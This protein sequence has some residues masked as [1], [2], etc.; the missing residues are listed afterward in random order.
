VLEMTKGKAANYS[1]GNAVLYGT[2]GGNINI[3][4]QGR[5]TNS[6]G[7]T[8]VATFTAPTMATNIQLNAQSTGSSI[9]GTTPAT[10]NSGITLSPTN[11]DAAA[12]ATGFGS[13]AFRPGGASYSNQS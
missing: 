13:T 9:S 3:R 4:G 12:G 1:Y 8:A 11:I 6:T 5:F 10:I 2:A 7:Q